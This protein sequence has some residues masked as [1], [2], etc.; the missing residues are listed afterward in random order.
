M[1]KRARTHTPITFTSAWFPVF[2]NPVLAT[3]L[4]LK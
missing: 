4:L 2:C 1:S 3:A